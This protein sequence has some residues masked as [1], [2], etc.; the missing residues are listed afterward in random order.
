MS[1]SFGSQSAGC[2][3]LT[4]HSDWLPK[5]LP[6]TVAH[7]IRN[8]DIIHMLGTTVCIAMQIVRK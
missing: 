4:V 1:K 2:Q 7:K 3:V 6:G 8:Q 5:R